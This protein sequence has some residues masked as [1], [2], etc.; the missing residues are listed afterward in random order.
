[1]ARLNI[2][3][4][5][6]SFL[7]R[8][9]LKTLL[10]QMGKP[11]SMEECDVAVD[12]LAKMLRKAK[13]RL[14]IANPDMLTATGAFPREMP[15]CDHRIFYA[16]LVSEQTADKAKARFDFLLPAHAD[17]PS[18]SRRLEEIL[19]AIFG[20]TAE[21]E[22]GTLSERELTILKHIALGLTNSDIGEQLFISPH[23][24]M[25]HRKN[26]T[27]KLGIKTVSGLT[28]Y[29]ILNKLIKVEEL[30]VSDRHEAQ[31]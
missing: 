3:C 24:V 26:I 14:V 29:A 2:L 8:E 5:E 9:G 7:L 21:S 6:S 17:K 23:T 16:G 10:G 1:M 22:T 30:Q 4:I 28:V 12:D 27:R 31:L 20:K 11:F 25:T 15:D 18:L 13:P 19:T